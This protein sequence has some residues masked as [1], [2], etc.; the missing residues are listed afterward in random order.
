MAWTGVTGPYK[1]PKI[2]H[3]QDRKHR[4][5]LPFFCNLHISKGVAFAYSSLQQVCE[6]RLDLESDGEQVYDRCVGAS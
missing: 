6:G 4:F 1:L 5:L 2:V 3:T